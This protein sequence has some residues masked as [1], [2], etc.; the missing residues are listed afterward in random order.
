MNTSVFL[1]LNNIPSYGYIP[2]LI[3]LFTL[4]IHF[5]CF[6]FLAIMNNTA[7]NICVQVFVWIYVLNSLGYDLGMEVLSMR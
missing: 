1:W 3:Y 6:R 5:D 2:C 4:D 7:M